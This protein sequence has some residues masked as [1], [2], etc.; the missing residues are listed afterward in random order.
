MSRAVVAKELVSAQARALKMPGLSRVYEA[1]ARQAREEHWGYEEYLHE[2]LSAEQT[3]RHD[4]AVGPTQ[5]A[6]A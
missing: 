2:V 3:S 5:N 4:S 6:G 1:L